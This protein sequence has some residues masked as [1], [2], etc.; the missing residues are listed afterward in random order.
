MKKTAAIPEHTDTPARISPPGCTPEK[1][2]VSPGSHRCRL[3]TTPLLTRHVQES[4]VY[5]FS[6]A[7][8]KKVHIHT[9]TEIHTYGYA[10]GACQHAHLEKDQARGVYTFRALRRTLQSPENEEKRHMRLS[11]QVLLL[12]VSEA[13]PNEDGKGEKNENHPDSHKEREVLLCCNRGLQLSRPI[14]QLP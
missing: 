9:H 2:T 11:K 7:H 5:R 13:F 8:I 1:R 14:S 3:V 10:C 4:H 6:T 12:H